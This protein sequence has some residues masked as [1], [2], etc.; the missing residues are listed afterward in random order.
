MAS[1]TRLERTISPAQQDVSPDVELEVLHSSNRPDDQQEFSL[2]PVDKGKDAWLFLVTCFLVEAIVWGKH[3]SSTFLEHPKAY[4]ANSL[5][6]WQA[7]L[8]RLAFFRITI[9]PMSRLSPI[10]LESRSLHRAL[11]YD[12]NKTFPSSPI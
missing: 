6:L 4:D 2:P 9:P 3:T 10:P 11:W 8:S 12:S 1:L 7:S 5:S